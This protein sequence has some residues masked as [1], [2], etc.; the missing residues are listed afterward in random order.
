MF[1]QEDESDRSPTIAIWLGLVTAAI[2]VIGLV[3]AVVT[4]GLGSGGGAGVHSLHGG[5]AAHAAD[6]HSGHG[7]H[8]ADEG[9]DLPLSGTLLSK[10]YFALGSADISGE[11]AREV[12]NVASDLGGTSGRV[13]IAGFHDA[14]GNA[15]FNAELA[16]NR[17]KAVRA[18]LQAAGVARDRIVLRKPESTTGDGSQA[19]ARRVE[20]RLID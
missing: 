1:Q 4:G 3:S 19:E 10:V 6:T 13:M 14:T 18:S 5:H 8:G 9:L 20:M 7:G 16:K 17:A 12:A 11:A 15:A 2:V